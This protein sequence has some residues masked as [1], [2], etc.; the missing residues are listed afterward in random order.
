MSINTRRELGT[1]YLALCAGLMAFGDTSRLTAGRIGP[2]GA[3]SAAATDH[4]RLSLAV[5]PVVYQLD[6]SSSERGYHYIFYGNAFFINTEGYLITA[7]HVLSDFHDGGQPYLLLRLP[8]APPR[9]IKAEVV[10]IDAVHDVAVLRAETN[11]FAGRYQVAYLALDAQKPSV[12]ATLIAGALRPS[13]L[14][15][16]HTFDA[17][18]EDYATAEVMQYTSSALAKGQ[19]ATDLFLFSHEVIRGQ[20]GAPIVDQNEKRVV[21]IVE[22]R[23]LRPTSLTTARTGNGNSTMG[24]AIPIAYALPLLLEKKV[25]WQQASAPPG[26]E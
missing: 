24:A 9:L 3:D 13:R 7:A 18:Q 23:W 17:P 20:S 11:P 10:A 19:A 2:T 22:G 5:C 12:G 1:L 25:P 4:K 16:P 8:E 21:G 6:E 26:S 15:D 14:K